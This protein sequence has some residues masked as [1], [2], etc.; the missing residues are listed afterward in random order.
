MHGQD[1]ILYVLVG[2]IKLNNWQKKCILECPTL[3]FSYVVKY[4]FLRKQN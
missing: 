4:T 2:R 3:R 1:G